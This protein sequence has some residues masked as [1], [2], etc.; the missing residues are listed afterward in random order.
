MFC[1]LIQGHRFLQGQGI[2]VMRRLFIV[3]LIIICAFGVFA[4]SG[5]GRTEIPQEDISKIE[6]EI[7]KIEEGAKQGDAEAQVKL[8]ENT[9]GFFRPG[10]FLSTQRG[11]AIFQATSPRANGPETL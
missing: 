3:S 10:P 4:V 1:A 7:S 2:Q 9:G 11:W 5:Q 8:G 6:E